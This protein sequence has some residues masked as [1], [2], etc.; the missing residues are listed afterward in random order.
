MS[1][2]QVHYAKKGIRGGH[3]RNA[4][5]YVL[6]ALSTLCVLALQAFDPP[7][8]REHLESVLYDARMQLRAAGAPPSD[9]VVI[10]SV[11]EPS[12]AKLGRWPWPRHIQADLIDAI[13]AD[14][15]SAI[16]IDILFTEP[17]NETSDAALAHALEHTPNVV[18]ATAFITNPDK[19]D[20]APGRP[21]TATPPTEVPYLWDHALTSIKGNKAMPWK[22]WLIHPTGVLAPPEEFANASTLASVLSP[23]D[24]DGV[25]RSEVLYLYYDEDVYPSLSLQV[26]RLSMGIPINSMMLIAG[27]GIKLGDRIIE[28]DLSGRVLLDY[29]GKEGS[30]TYIPAHEVLEGLVPKGTFTHRAVLV[31]TS[32][33]ATYD[34]KVTP[35]S[36]NMPGVEKNAT[37][38][39]N[40]LSGTFIRRTHLSIEMLL[41]A[42]LGLLAAL[43]LIH[44][45]ALRGSTLAITVMGIFTMVAAW[46][47]THEG[48]WITMLYPLLNMALITGSHLTGRYFFEEKRARKI[49]RMFS[50]YVSPSVVTSLIENPD[51]AKLGGENKLVTVLFSDICGFTTIS[52]SLNPEEVVSLLNEYFKVMTDVIFHWRGTFDKIVGDEIMAFWGAP[53]NQPDHAELAVRCALDMFN[54]LDT[55]HEKWTAQGKPLINI[56]I[57]LNTGEVLVGNIGAEDKKLD[58]TII[59][60]HVNAGAR[61]EALTRQYKARILMTEFTAEHI[62]SVIDAGKFGHLELRWRGTTKVKGKEKEL[63]IYELI[64]TS[65]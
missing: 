1:D 61:V 3:G 32:A 12:I 6:A 38:V 22:D 24:R 7:V 41:T 65:P 29:Y 35:L 15:P 25:I 48:L 59:G 34:L 31:G 45:P 9:K 44:L 49:R 5:F 42:L 46:A 16:G 43:P 56:G 2:K 8:L 37:A 62:Q 58:Y 19:D 63:G 57:G 39:Q 33:I 47:F 23:P 13:N 18:L 28:T 30:F 17:E 54:K 11:D 14:N 26:A 4:F 64:E 60:D 10:V 36:A 40:I 51:M 20:A 53:L 21:G 55:L 27:R 50:S 52:E